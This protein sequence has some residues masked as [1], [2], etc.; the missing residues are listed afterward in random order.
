MAD[1]LATLKSMYEAWA[2]GD[3]EAFGKLLSDDYVDHNPTPGFADD[4]EGAKQFLAVTMSA[5]KDV[6]MKVEGIVV[7]GDSA[8]AHYTIEWTQVGDFM[9]VVPADGKRLIMRGHDFIRF[10]D[11]LIAELWHCEDLFGIMAQLGLMPQA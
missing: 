2:N 10:K 3:A 4:K 8:A 1:G 9:N 5:T 7:D 11:G 6:N